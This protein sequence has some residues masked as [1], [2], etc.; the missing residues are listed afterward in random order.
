MLIQIELRDAD[1]HGVGDAGVKM[2]WNHQKE[3]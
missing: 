2:V 1:C 3:S